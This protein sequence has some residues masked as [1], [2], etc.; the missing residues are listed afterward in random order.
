M[1]RREILSSVMRPGG[2]LARPGLRAIFLFL[3][4]PR[5]CQSRDQ[6]R[7]EKTRHNVTLI[8]SLQPKSLPYQELQTYYNILALLQR[9]QGTLRQIKLMGILGALRSSMPAIFDISD[10]LSVPQ[11]VTNTQKSGAF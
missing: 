7:A 8:R 6:I 10:T 11:A 4:Q 9:K 3:Y 5:T 2:A 1:L